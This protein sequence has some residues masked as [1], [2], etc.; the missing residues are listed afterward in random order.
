MSGRNPEAPRC[1]WCDA[2]CR[3]Q[4]DLIAHDAEHR[5]EDHR[6]EISTAQSCRD[7]ARFEAEAEAREF[8]MDNSR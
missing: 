6:R 7:D 8:N 1:S 2:R 4:G 5:R 3:N